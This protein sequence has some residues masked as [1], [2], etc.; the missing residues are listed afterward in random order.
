VNNLGNS[1]QPLMGIDILFG[2]FGLLVFL[3]FQAFLGFWAF[4]INTDP[5][6]LQI[7]LDHFSNCLMT[8]TG[9]L[10]F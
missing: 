4:S 5:V 1:Q 10:A 2:L 8:F 9:L 3:I 6:D 7:N